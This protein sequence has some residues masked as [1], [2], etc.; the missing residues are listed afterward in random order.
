MMPH[1]YLLSTFAPNLHVITPNIAEAENLSGKESLDPEGFFES[2]EKDPKIRSE[3]CYHYRR[4]WIWQNFVRLSFAGRRE[5]NLIS[6][7]KNS[8][9]GITRVWMQFFCQLSQRSL[10]RGFSLRDAFELANESIHKIIQD[11]HHIGRGL[12]ITDP[13]FHVYNDASRFDILQR[14]QEA[15]DYIESIESLGHSDTRNSIKHCFC[16]KGARKRSMM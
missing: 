3:K 5:S 4:A 1:H 11:A 8:N 2:R 9:Q 10:L 13:V 12:P 6:S 15:V 14:I 16:L 7:Q